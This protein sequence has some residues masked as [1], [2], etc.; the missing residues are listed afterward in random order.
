M[1]ENKLL[2]LQ[3]NVQSHM[4]K[5]QYIPSKHTSCCKLPACERNFLGLDEVHKM[6]LKGREK[7]S[8]W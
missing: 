2:I 1:H 6:Q 7:A 8:K 3:K 4:S 5:M